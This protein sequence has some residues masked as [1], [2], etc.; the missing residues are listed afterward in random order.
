MIIAAKSLLDTNLEPSREEIKAALK[1][2][3]CRC[4]GYVKIE[5]AIRNAA[6]FFRE[7]L[8]IPQKEIDGSLSHRFKRV[9]A[10]EKILGTGEFVD[11]II[12]PDMIYAKALRT[13][14]PRA[15]IRSIDISKAQAHPDCVKILTAADVP[16]NICG[17]VKQDW[18]VMIPVGKTTRYIG[19][20]LALVA[21]N[22]QES[23]DEI[24]QLIEVEY[25]ELIPITDPKEAMKPD[26]PRIHEEGNILS[27][28]HLKRGDSEKAIAESDYVVTQTYSTP[29]GEH[30]FMEPECAIAA[31]EGDDGL[32][33]FTASQSVYDEQHEISRMLKIPAEKVHCVSKLV[34]GGFGGKEDMSVQH[35]A[36][37]MAWFTKKPVKVKFS[38]Q[39]SINYHVKRHAME[40]EFT[41][42]CD[43]NGNLTALKA[44]IIADTGAYASLGGPVLQRACTHAG[45]PYHYQNVDITGIAVYT[46]NV[47]AGAF[48]GFGVTQSC[49]A[50]ENNLNLL[51]EKVGIS[52][53]EMRMRNAIRPGEVLP[54][55]QIADAN[56]ALVESILAVKEEFESHPYAGIACGFKNSGLGV[57]VED[58]GRC[59]L[60]VENGKIHIRT[61][62]ACM[63]QGVG[64]M[65][66]Q[67]VYQVTKINPELMV[68]ERADTSR[69]PDAGTSTASRQTLLTGEAVKRAAQLLQNEL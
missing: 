62:A 39:E 1:G 18:D 49:F 51:A 50:I 2:N 13:R 67:I 15:V 30:A 54:N 45:G 65:C 60:S 21:A 56:T 37:L 52:P 59:I 57:G 17:H 41:T 66:T 64:T 12:L 36:A 61:S 26:A 23:L 38:R 24:I 19:D 53:W 29:C 63:G 10:A 11:D 34:G 68:H 14:Y 47:V 69:T 55:G 25:T 8:P 3:I 42:A 40:L 31:P 28:E 4:T 5:E 35:H 20:A 48:R 43:K 58:A 16:N 6:K 7:N 22:H 9:D 46:N 33:V 44:V 32:L 27:Q